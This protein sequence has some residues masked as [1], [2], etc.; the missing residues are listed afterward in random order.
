M[1]LKTISSIE[2]D[3]VE[4]IP[5]QNV[6]ELKFAYKLNKENTR[7]DWN[8]DLDDVYNLIRG[9]SPYPTAWTMLKNGNEEVM[10]K[11]Y[12]AEKAEAKHDLETGTLTLEEKRVKVAV[13][14]GFVLLKKSNSPGKEKCRLK[15]F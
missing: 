13:K 1:V 11:I 6:D 3:D 4:K 9:L 7:I 10:L 14:N 8:K 12:D 2:K 5:Q 15:I